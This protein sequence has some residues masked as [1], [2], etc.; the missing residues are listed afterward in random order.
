MSIRQCLNLSHRHRLPALL[1]AAV[2]T[3][4][5]CA[6]YTPVAAPR[7][8]ENPLPTPTPMPYKM[9][10]GDLLSIR[11]YGNTELN[12]E[13]PIRP[14]GA[15]SLPFI[16]DIQAAGRTPAE[17]DEELTRRFTGELARPRIAVVVREFG[18]QRV[19]VGGEVSK[20]GVLPLRGTVTLFQALQE[21]GGLTV[22]ARRQQVV[23]IRT[24]ADGKRAGRIVDVRPIASG[25]RPGNDVVLQPLDIIFVPRNRIASL[26][27]FIDQYVRQVLP[28]QPGLGFYLGPK[29]SSSSKP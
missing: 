13:V 11:F 21:A 2:F 20:P 26:D 18:N 22:A 27:L 23:L 5:G 10:Q 4:A 29:T 25:E 17:L 19:Y 14:D 9:V 7:A 3:L 24:D 1:A 6:A 28:I 12:E 8:E 16:G 15:I